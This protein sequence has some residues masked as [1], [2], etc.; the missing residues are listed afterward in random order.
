MA[1]NAHPA[2]TSG[3]HF[4]GGYDRGMVPKVL[5]AGFKVHFDWR[6]KDPPPPLFPSAVSQASRETGHLAAC[7][8]LHC[9]TYLLSGARV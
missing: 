1:G 6:R 3:L 8:F 2:R 7:V 9:S 5:F 4:F